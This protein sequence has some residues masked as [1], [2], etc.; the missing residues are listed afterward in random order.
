MCTNRENGH[1]PTRRRFVAR[2]LLAVSSG[3]AALLAAVI[4]WR[5]LRQSASR[6]GDTLLV[7]NPLL[8]PDRTAV[9]YERVNVVVF[10]DGN[11][12]AAMSSVCTHLGCTLTVRD[13]GF[14]CPCHGSRFDV[15]GRR[16]TGPATRDLPRFQVDL[17]ADGR[18]IVRLDRRV[19][20][21]TFTRLS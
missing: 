6:A 13:R 19:T 11:R 9:A 5:S 14:E 4:G 18:A 12:I 16:L 7:D 10:R 8:L 20:P 3:V 2:V 15:L 1:S 17:L 21:G